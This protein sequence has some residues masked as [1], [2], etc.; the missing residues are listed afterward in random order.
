MRVVDGKVYF[1]HIMNLDTYFRWC[2]VRISVTVLRRYQMYA[3]IY[4]N[5]M[6]DARAAVSVDL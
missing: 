2:Y 3:D 6:P 1:L 4:I 5:V